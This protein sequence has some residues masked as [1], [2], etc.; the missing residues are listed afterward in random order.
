MFCHGSFM[1]IYIFNHEQTTFDKANNRLLINQRGRT[2]NGWSAAHR[3]G[4]KKA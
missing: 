3:P 4:S 1:L 2:E